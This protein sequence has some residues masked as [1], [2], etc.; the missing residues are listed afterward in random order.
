[1][2]PYLNLDGDSGVSAYEIGP[3]HI[4]VEFRHGAVYRYDQ[5]APG[6]RHVEQMKLRAIAGRGLA[7]YINEHVR[8]RYVKK[9]R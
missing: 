7:T 4:D 2:A 8:K 6:G 3:D 9:L 5:R 1:M